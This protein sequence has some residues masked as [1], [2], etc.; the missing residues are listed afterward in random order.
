MEPN[1]YESPLADTRMGRPRPGATDC[2]YT[3]NLRRASFREIGRYLSP[4]RERWI[5]IAK[6]LIGMD[7]YTGGCIGDAHATRFWG[8]KF[9]PKK[10]PGLVQEGLDECA[11]SGLAIDRFC[12]TGGFDRVISY[13]AVLIPPDRRFWAQLVW[14]WSH[15]LEQIA[16]PVWIACTSILSSGTLTSTTNAPP[17]LDLPPGFEAEY[18]IQATVGETVQRHASRL[19]AVA[20]E[21]RTIV[22]AEEAIRY[23]ISRK[24][25]YYRSRRLLVQWDP[26]ELQRLDDGPCTADH[27]FVE[28]EPVGPG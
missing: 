10:I 13:G 27:G 2:Y 9:R 20:A 16:A 22:D 15:R 7:S 12:S 21:C 23:V 24:I 1:P 17:S 25:E 4:P 28:I 6:K 11:R 3:V 18:H 19:Q 5:A 8:S 26:I 14:A